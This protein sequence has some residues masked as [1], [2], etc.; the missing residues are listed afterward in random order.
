MKIIDAH[1]HFSNAE[2]L[3]NTA[4]EISQVDYSVEGLTKE[5][6]DINVVAGIIM[7]TPA[8]NIELLSETL[9]ENKK[10]KKPLLF[11][12][13]G[14]NPIELEKDESELLRIEKE[15]LKNISIGIKIYAGYFPY[16]VYDPIY[17]PIY[18]LA[19]KYNVPVAIHCGDTQ[20]SRG[21]LKYS[22]PLTVDEVA[23]KHPEISFIICHLGVPWA[24]DTG[25]LLLKNPNVYGDLSGLLAGNKGQV[26]EM[27]ENRLYIELLQQGLIFA[28]RY[29]K[30]L[31]GSDWPLVP[32]EPYVEF[33]KGI[34]PEE[35]H[36]DIFYNN[37]LNVYPKIKNWIE[38]AF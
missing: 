31:F 14:V 23:V 17:E 3:F 9:S 6:I 26:L 35:Y 4:R 5:F 15:L 36:R 32:L 1:F 27:T 38:N 30:I 33:I 16:Y 19:M 2:G 29:D 20:S 28:N 7:T 10:G 12:C 25:E 11:Q 18:E 21:L 13:I 8:N 34:I 22:H 24:L 37:A